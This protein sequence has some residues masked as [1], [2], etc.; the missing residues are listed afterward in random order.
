VYKLLLSIKEVEI[1]KILAAMFK[2]YN[3]HRYI[4]LVLLKLCIVYVYVD[5]YLDSESKEYLAIIQCNFLL[6][7]DLEPFLTALTLY[8]LVHTSFVT[9]KDILITFGGA[10]VTTSPDPK[11]AILKS[12]LKKRNLR[13]APP[14][15]APLVGK[16]IKIVGGNGIC[17][18]DNDKATVMVK[19]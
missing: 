15:V 1:L 9:S 3:I 16:P 10:I 18:N 4:L 5:Y 7:I 11:R 14:G 12:V 8:V 2:K 17:L 19:N 13:L 6:T